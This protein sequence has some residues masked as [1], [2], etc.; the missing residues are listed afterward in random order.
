MWS[1]EKEALLWH[2]SKHLGSESLDQRCNVNL[3]MR[4]ILLRIVLL[5]KF[6]VDRHHERI[7]VWGYEEICFIRVDWLYHKWSFPFFVEF[8]LLSYVSSLWVF[9]QLRQGHLSWKSAPWLSCWRLWKLEPDKARFVVELVGIYRPKLRAP[10]VAV[11][12]FLH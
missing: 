3:I 9:W 10:G 4:R 7:T 11:D 1:I 12:A 2:S 6:A 5:Q 8:S